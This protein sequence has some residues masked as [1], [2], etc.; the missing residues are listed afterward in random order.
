VHACDVPFWY[1]TWQNPLFYCGKQTSERFMNLPPQLAPPS[2]RSLL[3]D[4]K[5]AVEKVLVALHV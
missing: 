4:I 2:L 3:A 1:R 5:D